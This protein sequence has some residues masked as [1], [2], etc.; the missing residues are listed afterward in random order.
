MKLARW[1][2]IHTAY[3]VVRA[4]TVS[5]AAEVLGVH[6]ATVIRHIDALEEQMGVQLFER[7]PR[8]YSPTEAGRALLQVASV[9]D[10][11]FQQLMTRLH[12]LAPEISGDLIVTAPP[13][14]MPFIICVVAAFRRNFP[15]IA[16]RVL[17]DEGAG[18]LE[19]GEAHVAIRVGSMPRDPDNSVQRLVSLK[20]SLCASPHY[21]EQHGRPGGAMGFDGHAFVGRD[22]L[23]HPSPTE[24]WLRENVPAGQ[25]MLRMNAE[26]AR[27]QAVVEGAGIGF[28]SQLTRMA[29]PHL[30]EIVPPQD[31]WAVDLWVV[32]HVDLHRTPKVQAF[33]K[34]LTDEVVSWQTSAQG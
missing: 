21:V 30:L 23:D 8:G 16:L 26:H 10:E 34:A 32:T 18:K 2:E 12:G 15:S 7:H 22:N 19:Y 25:V 4:G 33:L 24:A 11:Q 20:S 28:V 3:Q 1:D 9:T 6:H 14:A 5:G 27:E 31:D 17:C 13:S 29:H